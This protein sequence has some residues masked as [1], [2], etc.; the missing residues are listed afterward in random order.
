MMGQ[1]SVEPR[2][3]EQI[4]ATI[5]PLWLWDVLRVILHDWGCDG[6]LRYSPIRRISDYTRLNGRWGSRLHPTLFILEGLAGFALLKKLTSACKYRKNA[7]Q[8][9]KQ[10]LRDQVKVQQTP[11]WS[12]WHLTVMVG[13]DGAATLA[14]QADQSHFK[15]DAE[16]TSEQR[17][18]KLD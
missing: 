17:L 5:T 10:E 12:Q 1:T 18:F 8:E 11:P 2:E 14:R 7:Q 15:W 9:S 3:G 4:I 13:G 16:D 6:D